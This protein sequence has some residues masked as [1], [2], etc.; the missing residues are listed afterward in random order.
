M[1]LKAKKGAEKTTREEVAFLN[2][3]A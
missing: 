2:P 3:S 1:R